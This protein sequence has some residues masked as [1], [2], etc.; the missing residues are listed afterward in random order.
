MRMIN[1]H[2]E[3]LTYFEMGLQVK[4]NHPNGPTDWLTNYI[5]PVIKK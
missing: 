4:I 3:K 2:G 5:S 1:I